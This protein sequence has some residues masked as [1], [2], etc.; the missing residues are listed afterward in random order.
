MP[1]PKRK[2]I[3]ANPPVMEGFKPFGIP[4]TN[5]E[6]VVLLF[7]EYESIRLADYEGLTQQEASEKMNISRP[8][9]TR[10]YERARRTIACAFVEGKAIFI[11][12][13]DYHSDDYW[14]RC[15]KCLKVIISKQ[16]IKKCAY[17]DSKVLRRL[18]TPSQNSVSNVYCICVHCQKKIPH[19]K[20]IR[21]REISCTDCGKLMMR[22]G[23]YHHQLYLNKIKETNENCNSNKGQ[24]D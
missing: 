22:E 13:G 5:L 23:G 21:C 19:Q 10:V 8:T 17:C 12:G 2:R 9:F 3:I 4:I 15:E 6:P 1:R 18:N 11:E 14:T 16:D 20:G 24:P 7:E